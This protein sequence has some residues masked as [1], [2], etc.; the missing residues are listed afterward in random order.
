MQR[1]AGNRLAVAAGYD[2]FSV[3]GQV[4]I[5]RGD[6]QRIEQLF[7]C[8]SSIAAVRYADTVGARI[9]RGRQSSFREQARQAFVGLT[10]GVYPL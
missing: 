4:H 9:R 5:L 2:I 3:H 6:K 10:L 7:H 8:G 1:I